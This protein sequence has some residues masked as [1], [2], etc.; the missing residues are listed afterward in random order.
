MSFLDE[1]SKGGS[2]WLGGAGPMS[3]IV[4]SSRIRLARNIVG[5]PFLT[6][7]D[8]GQRRQVHRMLHEKI[9]AIGMSDQVEFVDIEEASDLDRQLLVERH[10]ISRQHADGEGSRGVALSKQETVALMINEEDHLRIQ[11]VAGG[12]ELES[13]WNKID[14]IDTALQGVTPF[15]F[16]EQYGFLT[17][18][19]TNVGTGIRVSAMLHLPALKLAGELEKVSRATRDMRLAVR[20]LHGEGSEATGDFYQV[21]NQ[22]T[23]GKSEAEIMSEFTRIVT[24]IV[25]Y[26]KMAREALVRERS[27][28]LD[29]KIF[30]AYGLLN[31]ARILSTEEAL[32]LL[33]HLR[34]GVHLGRVPDVPLATINQLF[35]Q[36][37]PAHLQ[38]LSGQRLSGEARGIA[39]ADYIRGL[40]ESAN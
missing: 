30:R 32:F 15:A 40:L 12:L 3:E 16:H 14:A 29:D 8:E 26:E 38:K 23:L 11:V 17:A 18:C 22:T 39:R 28:A 24:R 2:G 27:A 6:K 19:P 36:S 20:G 35:F 5:F 10:L 13:L 37:Q 1:L 33:S 21:S 9:S 34:M 31:S 25:D 7:A 4:I